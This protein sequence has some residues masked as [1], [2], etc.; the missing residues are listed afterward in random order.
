MGDNEYFIASD[1]SPFVEFTKEAIYL[2]D[3]HMALI[4]LEGG[5]DIRVINDNTK[6]DAQ[7][8][9]LKLSLEQIEKGGYDHFMLKE[10]F[11]QPKSIHDTMRGRILLDEGIIKMAGIWDNLDRIRKAKELSSLLVVLHGM[12]VLL[13]NILS[14]S[15]QEYLLK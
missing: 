8:Q 11:E 4:S 7:I 10:I 9:E 5:V 14:K 2:E 1:A 12:Q 15:L 13:V 6:V 3:G